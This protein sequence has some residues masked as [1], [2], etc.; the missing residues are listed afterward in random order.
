MKLLKIAAVVITVLLLTGAAV[1]V[2]VVLT[3]DSA[4]IKQEAAQAVL[5]KTGRTLAVDGELKLKFWPS[6]GVNIG[7]ARLTEHNSQQQFAAL[8]SAQLSV[9]VLP[10]LS[11]Q[12]IVDSVAL[13][14]AVITLVRDRNGHLNIDDLLGGKKDDTA[15]SA[16]EFDVAGIHIT[17]AQLTWR[18]ERAGKTWKISDLDCSTGHAVGT[19]EGISVDGLKVD[20]TGKLDTDNVSLALE[21]PAFS[22]KGEN[23]HAAKVVIRAALN[24]AARNATASLDIHDID[25]TLQALKVG[26]LVLDIE[27]K[28]G[29]KSLR[30]N[31]KTPLALDIEQRIVTLPDITGSFDVE[32]PGLPTRL[33]KLPIKG[34]IKSEYGK[35][36]VSGNLSTAFDESHIDA[37]FN[38]IGASPPVIGVE[39]NIDK[40]NVDRYLPPVSA[41]PAKTVKSG[42]DHIDLSALKSINASGS[43][44]VGEL[45]VNNIKAR[46]VR[47]TF[48]AAHG[49]VSI[50]PHSADL[51]GGHVNGAVSISVAGNHF[52]LNES[53]RGI[54]VQPLL[55]DA[56]GKDI[57]EGRGDV[58]LDIAT[59]GDTVAALK[60]TLSGSARAVLRDGAIKGINIAQSLRTAKAKL[61][62]GSAQQEASAT[63][64]TDFSELSASFKIVNGVAHN[65]DLVAKSPFLRL[66]GAGDIDIGNSRI[67]YLLKASVVSTAA[68]QGGKE[69][70]SLKGLTLPVH[71][72]GPL[73]K[74]SFKLELASMVSDST[75]A[76]IEDK[77][78]EIKQQAQDKVK[79]KLKGL[80]NK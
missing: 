12:I 22:R 69:A 60:K 2:Y 79:D 34:R 58:M 20:T 17:N 13:D 44:H 23:I 3:F 56:A 66:G 55:Q 61:S 7:K 50:A 49:N 78:Q 18:D 45:Q 39:L 21:I 41:A 33:L 28:V 75:K 38:I 10:L 19:K 71:V 37:R 54:D 11:K 30:G 24:G 1:V 47:M 46:D 70:D 76:R 14:G 42:D 6:L 31:I 16:P 36:A 77:K 35:P 29:D 9:R 15:S 32:L 63:D 57:V 8:N 67:D 74:P 25:G 80:F 48:K 73:E 4:W 68:G 72:T 5:A 26:G 53:L 65:D 40:L 27:A 51:Y 59:Q 52:A 64:K 62:G 43:L